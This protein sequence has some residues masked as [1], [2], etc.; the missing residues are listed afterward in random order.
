MTLSPNAQRV[1]DELIARGFSNQV[2]ELAQSTRTSA[3]AASALGCTL[4]Q[5][6][7]SLVFRTRQS[8]RAVLV[9]ASGKN[10]VNEQKLGELLGEAI[11]RADAYWVKE[12][13]G[14]PVG[15]VPPLG[16]RTKLLTFIDQDLM[17]FNQIW[18]AAGTPTAVFQLQPQELILMTEGRTTQVT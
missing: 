8:R 4:A 14:F 12:V 15:G 6:A 18:A 17:E 9:I 13:T 2:T 16:H 3:E 1:Q 11:E 7:K 5:I 10:R